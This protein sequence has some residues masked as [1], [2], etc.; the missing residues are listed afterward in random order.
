MCIC[1]IKLLFHHLRVAAIIYVAF[2]MEQ[3]LFVII[4]QLNYSELLVQGERGPKC[5]I[6]CNIQ[7]N[8]TY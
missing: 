7:I 4:C 3:N 5:F 1:M 8:G 2:K 6:T